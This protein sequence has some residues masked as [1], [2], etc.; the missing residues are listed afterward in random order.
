MILGP[1]DEIRRNQEIGGKFQLV[2]NSKFIIQTIAQFLIC[3]YTFLSVP[4]FQSLIA[5]FTQVFFARRP[6]R[7]AEFGVFLRTG[8]IQLDGNIAPFRNF[9][10]IFHGLRIILEHLPHFLW[11]FQIHFRGIAH[12]FWGSQFFVGS[13]ANQNIVHVV[14][15]LPEE[16]HVIGGNNGGIGLAGDTHQL[17][18]AFFLFLHA[19][20]LKL[21]KNI[22]VPKNIL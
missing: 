4:F 16:V 5:Y 3:S 1:V 7:R 13:D 17:R 6:V 20:V 15:F 19:M 9:Q 11:R 18:Q 10:R 14:I 21:Y 22:V 12:A 2:D 8:G